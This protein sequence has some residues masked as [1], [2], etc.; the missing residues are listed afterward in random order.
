MHF[1]CTKEQL[2]PAV[3][4]VE[5][6]VASQNTVPIITGT[7][8]KAASDTLILTS[9]NLELSIQT[10]ISALISTPG[11]L[12]VDGKLF[13]N[14][15]RKLP[16]A[17]ITFELNT[18]LVI[19]AGTIEFT[20]NIL[21]GE[22]FP[23]FPDPEDEMFTIPSNIL[24]KMIKNTIYACGK[25]E[26]RPYI[27][28]L[29]FE[30]NNRKFK[31]V[32]TDINR[33]SYFSIPLE[34]TNEDDFKYL[35]PFKTISELHKNLPQDE[36]PIKVYYLNTQMIFAF[37]EH[38]F[39]TR[40]ID[41]QF[42]N[43]LHLFPK[44]QPIMITSNKQSL[45]AAVDRASILDHNGAQIIILSIN[46]GVLEIKTPSNNQDQILEQLNVEHTGENGHAAF[47]AR[48]ILEMLKA[49]SAQQVIFE[50]NMELR[51]CL[52]KPDT[53]DDHLYILMPIRLN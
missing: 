34:N 20:L 43:Y 8:I 40:L 4:L 32:S 13:A 15:I 30:L 22:D 24:S 7:H 19:K 33:L 41:D 49:T 51:P 21:S 45:Q 23:A 47:S 16:D 36:T 53:D 39:A 11:E 14:I 17:P 1:Q 25:D 31:L 37:N 29:L 46:D 48:Y 5:K 44:N 38:K 10:K 42:P 35:V 9:T 12:I 50:F 3:S 2:L 18:K 28:G 6:A 26:K 27:S 52:L